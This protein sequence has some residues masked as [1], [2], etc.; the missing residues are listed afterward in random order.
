MLV[1]LFADSLN[2]DDLQF[3][4]KKTVVVAMHCLCS[5]DQLDISLVAVVEFTVR[6]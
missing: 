1:V 5:T 4:L 6:P 2:S 3:G